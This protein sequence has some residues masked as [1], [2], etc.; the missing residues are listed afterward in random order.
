[1]V[2][3]H[4]ILVQAAQRINPYIN[5]TPVNG[6]QWIDQHCGCHILFKCENLQRIGAFKLRGALNALLSMAPDDLRL[7][8]ATHS[9]GNHAQA[10]ALAAKIL[11]VSAYIVMPENS[12]EIKIQGVR[13][14]NGIITFCAP[15]LESREA[16]LAGVLES[17]GAQFVPPYDHEHIIA[18][19]A[20]AAMELLSQ[21]HDMDALFA[22]LGG[23]GLLSGTGLA[24]HCFSPGTRVYGA[25]PEN[26]DDG[27]RSFYSGQL[28]T[29]PP[30]AETMADGLR[31]HLSALTLKYIRANVT[32]VFTVSESSISE[33]M[34][35]IWTRLK[36]IVEPSAAVPL[37]ALIANRD[38]FEGQKVGIILSGGNVD[39]D[40]ILFV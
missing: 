40:R 29:N 16:K 23:G 1:M 25:E 33:A 27:R 21:H 36:V 14:L 4:G 9:S 13:E 17:T 18:G 8:V 28:E 7:G 39:L 10:L 24:A 30:G 22:P 3:D 12:P 2:I 34:E 35:M 6:N 38:K 26:V 5:T 20:T 19:Q 15:T 32:D 37:A 11:N 31:T